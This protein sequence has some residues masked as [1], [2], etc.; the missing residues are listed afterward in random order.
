MSLCT[1]HG[2]TPGR[3]DQVISR[4]CPLLSPSILSRNSTG[5]SHRNDLQRLSSNFRR[6]IIQHCLAVSAWPHADS[7]EPAQQKIS[8]Y[9]IVPGNACAL[10]WFIQCCPPTC[11]MELGMEGFLLSHLLSCHSFP[12]TGSFSII[13]FKRFEMCSH[14]PLWSEECACV[15][16]RKFCFMFT[17]PNQS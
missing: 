4:V 7:P 5:L 16:Y 9:H 6:P 10:W 1:G 2:I 8:Q 3:L 15:C 14:K 13:Q 11:G 12:I 17:D